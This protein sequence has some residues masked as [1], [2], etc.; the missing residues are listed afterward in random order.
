MSVF[1]LSRLLGI[2]DQSYLPRL[3]AFLQEFGNWLINCGPFLHSLK[4]ALCRFTAIFLVC[5]WKMLFTLQP[6]NLGQAKP[7]PGP[8][9]KRL[10][11][12]VQF[13]EISSQTVR[14][15]VGAYCSLCTTIKLGNNV[16]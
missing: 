3:E 16:V 2:G 6:D 15:T 14:R 7:G 9:F 12:L 13:F 5:C 1:Q 10:L 11:L 4:N 8:A